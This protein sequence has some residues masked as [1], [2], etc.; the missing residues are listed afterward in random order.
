MTKVK[1]LIIQMPNFA[2]LTQFLDF[3]LQ[4]CSVSIYIVQPP[5]SLGIVQSLIHECEISIFWFSFQNTETLYLGAK[6]DTMVKCP[7]ENCR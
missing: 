1:K 4:N 7:E 3:L 5:D 2:Y 6:N